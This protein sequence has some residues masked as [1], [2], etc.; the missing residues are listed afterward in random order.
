MLANNLSPSAREES[1][2]PTATNRSRL[3]HKR[4]YKAVR[5][6]LSEAKLNYAIALQNAA[7]DLA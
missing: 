1:S 2:P 7:P 3:G 5:K 4:I 6:R